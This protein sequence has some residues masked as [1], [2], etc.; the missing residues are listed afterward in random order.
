M[1]TYRNFI[2]H[3]KG[4]R[5][6]EMSKAELL[7]VYRDIDAVRERIRGE[8]DRAE[9]LRHVDGGGAAS[10]SETPDERANR[11]L[12]L[13]T[14]EVNT[15]HSYLEAFQKADDCLECETKPCSTGR[16]EFTDE[17][18]GGC[19]VLI[20]IPGFI[21]LIKEGKIFQ[22]WQK[23]MER[24]SLPAITGRVCP[25]EV[26]CQLSCSVAIKDEPV[27]IGR[28]ER[29]VA[30]YVWE[31]HADAVMEYIEGLR[32]KNAGGPTAGHHVAVIGSGPSGLT[33]A[34]DLAILGYGVTIFESLHIPGGVL[35]YGIPVFRLPK[36]VLD[37]E[38]RI[39]QMLGVRF[40]H[41]V[42]IGRSLT[43]NELFDTGFSSVF[44]GTGAGLPRL[45]RIPG[46]N[47]NHVY[48]AN[49]FLV[50]INLMRAYQEDAD[51]PVKVGENAVVVG[52]G[53]TAIDAARWAKRLGAKNVTLM[54]RRSRE[55]MP[56]RVEEVENAEEE[57][58]D[59]QLLTNPVEILDNGQGQVGAIRV[60]KMELGGPD[61]SG[62]RRPIPI[63]GS[64]YEIPMDTVITALGT[65]PN[66]IILQTTD[67]LDGSKWG[68]IQVK[69]PHTGET[70]LPDT[71]AGGDAVTGAATV[72]LA[73][74]AGK[75]AAAA[76]DR[77]LKDKAPDPEK[78]QASTAMVEAF[79]KPYGVKRNETL[80]PDVY[81]M[82]VQAPVVAK[83]GQAGQFV[84]VMR[85]ADS[86][87]IPLT[88]ADW[89]RETGEITLVYQVVG[90]GTADLERVRPGDTLMA[91][92]GP[93]G[94][95]S[96]VERK[97]GKVVMVAG[98]VGLAA[99]YPIMRAHHELGNDVHLVYGARN[100]ALFFWLDR[101]RGWLPQE[102]IHFS[103]NDGSAGTKGFVT[104][105]LKAEFLGKGEISFSVVIGP[106][107]MMRETA[108][109]LTAVDV[110][111]I[112]SLNPVMLDGS[113]MCGGCKVSKKS[114]K[115][116]EED[117]A[118]H[119]GP[120]RFAQDVDLDELVS[121]LSI[122]RAEE[123]DVIVYHIKKELR[124]LLEPEPVA[125]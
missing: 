84:L 45:M 120:D 17:S 27:E 38:L 104:D 32:E 36:K 86:E 23:L 34:C 105:V 125:A 18:T 106:A 28:L 123:A 87:R 94:K 63:E 92:S 68:T 12:Y 109:I 117:F 44:I 16:I 21:R 52:G 73:M 29:F 112:V 83:Y 80:V 108:K 33:V 85:D 118:C 115:M 90:K 96:L 11:R 65:S 14:H 20:D 62:R 110:P 37:R 30:D 53:F 64:E 58:I 103:T 78:F 76:I 116:G 41:N 15:G 42:T 124:K 1:D 25:Q 100:E 122:Y 74:G 113:A 69:D 119:S 81:E 39:A 19:P 101:I 60:V 95:P 111:T 114:G 79:A 77:S 91:I 71:Y 13:D 35:V 7:E 82:V 97:A 51:T 3:L 54:Y 56:A 48:S 102:K 24:D 6:H 59:L 10:S 107:I 70:S 72:I 22:A 98:G 88:I 26:Q 75:W 61:E 9:I 40:V 57:G 121:R 4:D 66:P 49:E 99:I 89:D 5:L 43:V 50:R 67:R 8:D 31:H 2:E 47:L 55:E 93:L 46:E